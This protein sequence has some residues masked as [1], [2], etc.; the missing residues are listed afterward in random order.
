ML[1]DKLRHPP[2][3]PQQNSRLNMLA[4][5][6]A[7]ATAERLRFA[8]LVPM[9]AR[10]RAVMVAEFVDRPISLI[11]RDC[12]PSSLLMYNLPKRARNLFAVLT[13]PETKQ[14]QARIERWAVR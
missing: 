13:C 9:P 2:N 3:R 1:R 12:A 6:S 14:S 8:R 5:D 11:A 7:N 4:N 10:R